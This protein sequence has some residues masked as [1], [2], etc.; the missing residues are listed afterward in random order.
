MRQAIA[1]IVVFQRSGRNM[2]LDGQQRLTAMGGRVIR[3]DGTQNSPTSAHLDLE[4]GR[5]VQG[6]IEG[7]PSATMA[8]LSHPD[9]DIWMPNGES[10]YPDRILRLGCAA[11]ARINRADIVVYHLSERTPMEDLIRF[12]RWWNTPG[13]QMSPDEVEALIASAVEG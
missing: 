5:W 9:F 7:Q 13:V 10:A 4:T 3:A 8:E 12:F 6:R 11:S 2:L 1:P